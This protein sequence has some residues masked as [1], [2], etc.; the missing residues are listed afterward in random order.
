MIKAEAKTDKQVQITI[1]GKPD[2]ILH[3]M[4]ALIDSISKSFIKPEDRREFLLNIPFMVLSMES[5]MTAVAMPKV[6]DL[7]RMFGGDDKW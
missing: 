1:E 7:K 3:E 6:D 2:E 4:F 5:K